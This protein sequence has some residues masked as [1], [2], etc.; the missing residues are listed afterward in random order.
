[1]SQACQSY[2]EVNL[3]NIVFDKLAFSEKSG[4]IRIPFQY[5]IENGNEI[6]L[7]FDAPPGKAS[8]PWYRGEKEYKLSADAMEI[9]KKKHFDSVTDDERKRYGIPPIGYPKIMNILTYDMNSNKKLHHVE[10]IKFF[11][12]FIKKCMDYLKSNDK[13]KE[14]IMDKRKIKKEEK[15]NEFLESI[16]AKG[17]IDEDE[18]DP[19]KYKCYMEWCLPFKR[20]DGTLTKGTKIILKTEQDGEKEL[21][22]RNIVDCSYTLFSPRFY[23]SHMYIDGRRP[24]N[25]LRFSVKILR[26]YTP[27]V[28]VKYTP[29]AEGKSKI[30][31]SI[32]GDHSLLESMKIENDEKTHTENEDVSVAGSD[33][34]DPDA[35]QDESDNEGEV[36]NYDTE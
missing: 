31:S 7:A 28:P 1:M 10:I 15:Y 11:K 34:G 24:N 26:G 35:N 21:E 12:K 29:K 2:D 23:I 5:K 32:I 16:V 18:N 17:P 3:K 13:F 6:K 4:Y 14:I 25:E 19:N 27:F 9:L 8:S 22:W 20:P 36:V 33:D 30:M